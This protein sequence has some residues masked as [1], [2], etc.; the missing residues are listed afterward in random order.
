[1]NS[2]FFVGRI[3]VN[4][5]VSVE[6]SK[7]VACRT[8]VC[9]V[10]LDSLLRWSYT[11]CRSA[12]TAS[13]TV[14]IQNLLKLCLKCRC[15]VRRDLFRQPYGINV[16]LSVSCIFH[17]GIGGDQFPWVKNVG[18]NLPVMSNILMCY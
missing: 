15:G 18:T 12:R 10:R 16:C 14:V 8:S 9:G 2:G 6:C 3:T 17:M 5:G 13:V 1:M 7:R 11:T 4:C